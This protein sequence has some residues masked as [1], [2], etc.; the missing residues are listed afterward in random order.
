[1]K[2]IIRYTQLTA[3]RSKLFLGLATLLLFAIALS[4]FLGSTALVEQAHSTLIYAANSSRFILVVGLIIFICN[5]VHHALESKEID[6][7]LTTPISRTYFICGYW[8]SFIIIALYITIPVA[9]ILT[10]LGYYM[11]DS[12]PLSYY[13]VWALSLFGELAIILAFSLTAAL[14]LRSSI[15]AILGSMAF[16]ILARMMAFFNYV[17]YNTEMHGNSQGLLVDYILTPISMLLPRLDLFS[18]SSWLIYPPDTLPINWLI[19]CAIYIPLLL[20]MATIDI[21]KKEF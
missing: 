20:A 11:M 6:F 19:Q 17:Q 15:S 5:H 2:S 4:L 10:M 21:N 12:I 9:T 7:L 1:M 14:I 3:L 13:L 8:L 18:K 16:Y